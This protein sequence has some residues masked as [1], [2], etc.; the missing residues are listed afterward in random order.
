MSNDMANDNRM[1]VLMGLQPFIEDLKAASAVA[2]D[3]ACT[4]ASASAASEFGERGSK[5]S[6]IQALLDFFQ[7]QQAASK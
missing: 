4:L 2:A 3:A 1:Q 6:I 7:R 5:A